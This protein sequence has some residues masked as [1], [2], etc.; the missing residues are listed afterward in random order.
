MEIQCK[1]SSNFSVVFLSSICTAEAEEP[2]QFGLVLMAGEEWWRTSS[3]HLRNFS[4]PSESS[5]YAQRTKLSL[6]LIKEGCLSTL[7]LS[8]SWVPTYSVQEEHWVWAVLSTCWSDACLFEM[9]AEHQGVQCALL[10]VINVMLQVDP[11]DSRAL[12]IQFYSKCLFIN[13]L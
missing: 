8:S 12:E 4:T 7:G 13:Y 3:N 6:C 2:T 11:R 9:C 5:R 1:H 10:S